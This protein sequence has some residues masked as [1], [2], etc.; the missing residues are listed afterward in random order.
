MTH[1]HEP[2]T[3]HEIL[4]LLPEADSIEAHVLD[5][6]PVGEPEEIRD[7]DE[8]GVLNRFMLRRGGN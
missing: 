5:D 1:E 8:D 3:E 7:V 4:E 2:D 6:V